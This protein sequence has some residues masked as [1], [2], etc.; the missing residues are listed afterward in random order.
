METW[1][2]WR[3]DGLGSL[4]ITP[5]HQNLHQHAGKRVLI[6]VAVSSVVALIVKEG[7]VG[8]RGQGRC[9][10]TAEA[11]GRHKEPMRTLGGR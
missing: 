7:N 8:E 5:L 6:R 11:R 4:E 9:P 10:A 1:N 3:K 2:H